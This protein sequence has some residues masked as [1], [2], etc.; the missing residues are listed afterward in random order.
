MTDYI[1]LPFSEYL[2]AIFSELKRRSSESAKIL[3]FPR[4][5]AVPIPIIRLAK[6]LR[7]H[8]STYFLELNGIMYIK[9][10]FPIC[11]FSIEKEAKLKRK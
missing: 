1:K 11:S 6:S 4:T 5:T 9:D 7:Q 10:K 2:N 8:Y 3:H